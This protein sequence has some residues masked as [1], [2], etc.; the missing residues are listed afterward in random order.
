MA[1]VIENQ[2]SW[3]IPYYK[4]HFIIHAKKW[5]K[6]TQKDAQKLYILYIIIVLLLLFITPKG[7]YG[8]NNT[9]TCVHVVYVCTYTDKNTKN[10]KY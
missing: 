6:I 1:I 8:I 9:C 2:V 7:S 10:A 5:T 4:Q 3:Y